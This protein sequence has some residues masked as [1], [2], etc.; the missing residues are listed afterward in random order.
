VFKR[1]REV[2]GEVD[3]RCLSCSGCLV[4][5]ETRGA[6]R[7][8]DRFR[9]DRDRRVT[10]YEVCLDCGGTVRIQTVN[11]RRVSGGDTLPPGWIP[12]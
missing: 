4:A 7:W 3:H 12:L 9:A 2:L 6:A 1:V 11:P 8:R 10:R 5:V